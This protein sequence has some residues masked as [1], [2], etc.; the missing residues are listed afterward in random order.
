M[1]LSQSLREVNEPHGRKYRN[2]AK[3]Y[4]RLTV[5]SVNAL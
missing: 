1:R 2:I 3:T 4:V 5:A